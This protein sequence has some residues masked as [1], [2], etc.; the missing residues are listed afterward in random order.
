MK[1]PK[2]MIGASD[3]YGIYPCA[4]SAM[5]AAALPAL[6]LVENIHGTH[7]DTAKFSGLIIRAEGHTEQFSI[8][9]ACFMPHCEI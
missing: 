8:R 7:D 9:G 6:P 2:K 1:S 5:Q 3:E 4:H